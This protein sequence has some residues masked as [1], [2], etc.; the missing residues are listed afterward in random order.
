MDLD[1]ARLRA[2]NLRVRFERIRDGYPELRR[3]LL[4]VSAT[5]TSD[6]GLVTVTVGPRGQ[7]VRLE[8][9]PRIYRRPDSRRLAA[10]IT[11]TIDAATAR[12]MSAVTELTRPYIPAEVFQT[13]LDFD[14]DTASR[15]DRELYEGVS[16]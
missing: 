13:H 10:T 3:A 5:A 14:F 4:A 9:D 8:L 12:A 16:R 2:E 11:A 15:P 6:D 1:A 7:V